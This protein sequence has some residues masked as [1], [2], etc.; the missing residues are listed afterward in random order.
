VTRWSTSDGLGVGLQA[1]ADDLVHSGDPPHHESHKAAV[2]AAPPLLLISWPHDLHAADGPKA[3]KL[4]SK[5]SLIDLQ[6]GAHST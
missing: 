4:T 6:Q 1:Q 3:T 2:P 5:V